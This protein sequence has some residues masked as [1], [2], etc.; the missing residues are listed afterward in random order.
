MIYSSL[1]NEIVKNR[2]DLDI[3]EVDRAFEFAKKA[4]DGQLRF[5]G[6]PYI[7]HPVAATQILLDLN[8]DLA[9]VQ[10]CLMHDVTEDTEVTLS[11][12]EQHFGE[13]VAGLVERMERLSVVKLRK[14]GRQDEKW[15]K[16]FLGMANDV[17]IVFIKLSDRLHNMRTLQ[18]VPKEKQKR[19]ANETLM[20]HA[21][22]ASRLGIYGIKSELED[23]CFKF[24]HPKE[25]AKLEKQIKK[26]REK[27][28][29]NIAFATS[30]IEQLL[31]R[32]GVKVRRVE[33]RMKFLWSIYQ[34]MARKDVD[35]IDDIYDIFAVRVILPDVFLEE[36]E[37]FS[38]LYSTLGIIHSNYIPL[39]DKFKDYVAVPKPNAYRSLHTTVLGLGGSKY[40]E[41]TEIQIRTES[42]HREAEIG[43]ASHW[44]YKEGR[45][46]RI[47]SKRSMALRDALSS[48]Q[49]LIDKY[50]D[51]EEIVI[52]WVERYQRMSFEDRDKVAKLLKERG[53]SEKQLD[54]IKKGRSLG[55]LSMQP[56]L[57][58]QLAWLRGLAGD[59]QSEKSINIYPNKIFV[60]TP[61]SD[62]LELPKG[63]TPLDF[64]YAIHSEV[65]HKAT[66]A[67]VNGKIVPL[68]YELSN[69]EMVEI[70]TRSNA[71]PS[72]LW[73]SMVKTDQ[74]KSKIRNWFNRQD[75]E[76]H[77]RVGR[78]ALNKELAA[79]GKPLLDEKLALLKD[80]GGKARTIQ[81]RE[82]LLES[83]GLK[84]MTAAQMMKT[85]FGVEPVKKR[86]KP[87][88]AEHVKRIQDKGILVTGEENL[89]VVLSS[90]CKPKVMDPIIGYVTRGKSIRIHR[91]NCKELS[92]LEGERFVSAVW[93]D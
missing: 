79:L 80:Y 10:A 81:E 25:Y 69:G 6:E 56:N 53:I 90:C 55:Q 9:C 14:K 52:E 59:V 4:H 71:K 73:V 17:R 35:G 39:Q 21:A 61:Q 12:I 74:A 76:L 88:G 45:V 38:H 89:P 31:M 7:T 32:E 41:P 67:K 62:I 30:E 33:G 48:V 65:G 2:P 24:L 93:E 70:G 36:K 86:R 78:D 15:K 66:H 43:V 34:K 84:S 85:L 16:L 23:L 22:I 29:E 28:D 91:Q 46:Q 49:A 11:E 72:K 42:M 82:E 64:A 44:T 20:V 83:V 37:N 50:S 92:G 40:K 60:L 8:P 19:I 27:S 63:S 68:D 26:Y 75:K 13:E 5:S 87:I 3:N 18:Y 57:D 58:T 51:I 77:L 54:D 1:R 47:D